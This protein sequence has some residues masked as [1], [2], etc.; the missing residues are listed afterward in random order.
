MHKE[1]KYTM[2]VI[3]IQPIPNLKKSLNADAGGCDT[4]LLYVF[5]MVKVWYRVMLNQVPILDCKYDIS[6]PVHRQTLAMILLGTN[7]N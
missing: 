3:P 5:D 7:L 4:Q 1:S 6:F 2:Q